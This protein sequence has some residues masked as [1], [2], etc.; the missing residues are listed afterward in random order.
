M[1]IRII[2][3]AKSEINIDS[4]ISRD[5]R[6]LRRALGITKSTFGTF[7]A[8]GS[9]LTIRFQGDGELT[10]HFLSAISIRSLAPAGTASR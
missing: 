3:E 2:C 8:A 4:F 7:L 5:H 1:L 10:V 9:E 6:L